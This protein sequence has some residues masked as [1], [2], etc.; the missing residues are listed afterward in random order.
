MHDDVDLATYPHPILDA[1]TIII[2]QR[3]LLLHHHA[4]FMAPFGSDG[5]NENARKAELARPLGVRFPIVEQM[6]NE[7]RFR[8]SLG[9]L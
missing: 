7:E 6:N 9:G 4:S 1:C 8:T 5:Q 2:A 3:S